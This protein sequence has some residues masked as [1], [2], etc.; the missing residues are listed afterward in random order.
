MSKIHDKN[1]SYYISAI[2]IAL[3]LIIAFVVILNSAN[4]SAKE[5][6]AE[7]ASKETAV[8]ECLNRIDSSAEYAN[9]DLATRTAFKMRICIINSNDLS[10]TDKE[11]FNL[12]IRQQNAK[13]IKR[14]TETSFANNFSYCLTDAYILQN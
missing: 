13:T 6:Q 9:D 1:L 11:L 4:N 2:F 8:K 5:R 10:S 3:V 7:Q 12:C 14:R